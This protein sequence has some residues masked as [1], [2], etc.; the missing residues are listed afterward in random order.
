MAIKRSQYEIL[1]SGVFEIEA[2]AKRPLDA[3]VGRLFREH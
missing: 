1:G 3:V 2:R